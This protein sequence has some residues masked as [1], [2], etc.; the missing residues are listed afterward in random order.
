MSKP[1]DERLSKAVSLLNEVLEKHYGSGDT[2]H[3]SVSHNVKSE[4]QKPHGNRPGQRT[5]TTILSANDLLPDGFDDANA[6]AQ[7][8]YFL[9]AAGRSSPVVQVGDKFWLAPPHATLLDERGAGDNLTVDEADDREVVT[10]V[11]EGLVDKDRLDLPDSPNSEEGK[12]FLEAAAEHRKN[13]Y[14]GPTTGRLDEMFGEML[15]SKHPKRAPKTY[16]GIS[17]QQQRG[18]VK[19]VVKER[20]RRGGL[21]LQ[22]MQTISAIANVLQFNPDSLVHQEFLGDLMEMMKMGGDIPGR[23]EAAESSAEQATQNVERQQDR[24]D[25]QREARD[26]R[27]DDRRRRE[28]GRRLGRR[29]E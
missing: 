18:A 5:Q 2:R 8:D 3:P 12:R 4:T 17:P 1:H 20:K 27:A 11:G 10:N 29:L 19:A 9:R 6:V 16:E 28:R 13:N 21:P 23:R 24:A 25:D 7:M 14:E 22:K 26:D 15:R